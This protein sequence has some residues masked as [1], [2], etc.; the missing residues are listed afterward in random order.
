LNTSEATFVSGNSHFA[1]HTGRPS[2]RSRS[3]CS[4]TL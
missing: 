2:H 4:K 3:A 1:A